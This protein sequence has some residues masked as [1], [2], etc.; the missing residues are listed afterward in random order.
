MLRN[1]SKGTFS[2]LHLILLNFHTFCYEHIVTDNTISYE[3][4][5]NSICSICHY[6]FFYHHQYFDKYKHPLYAQSSPPLCLAFF[7]I[8]H[9][10]MAS[11]QYGPL[12]I[13]LYLHISD[14]M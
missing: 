6:F 7:L 13:A 14:A 4:T 5:R 2:T 3:H 11:Y 12:P 10:V 9:T 1:S 8:V